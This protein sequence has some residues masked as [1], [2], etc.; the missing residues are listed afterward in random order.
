MTQRPIEE[1]P[2]ETLGAIGWDTRE[3]IDELTQKLA[4]IRTELVRRN[5]AAQ[6]AAEQ[7]QAVAKAKA[8]LD[9]ASADS[10][11]NKAD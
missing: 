6:A 1:I 3:Q 8:A 9:A 7:Q 2:S 11:P 4:G 10:P 5:R